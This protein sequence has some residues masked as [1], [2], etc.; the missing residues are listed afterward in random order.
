MNELLDHISY[1]KSNEEA[2]DMKNMIIGM[3][4]PPMPAVPDGNLLGT[5]LD[6]PDTLPPPPS[7]PDDLSFA[8]ELPDAL[9]PP[10]NLLPGC[11]TGSFKNLPIPP[12]LD[13]NLTLYTS[14]NPTEIQLPPPIIE[15]P[16]TV[17]EIL[18]F[19]NSSFFDKLKHHLSHAS[20]PVTTLA[21]DAK[22]A[23]GSIIF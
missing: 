1:E 17:L 22:A 5:V 13:E 4:L 3:D 21:S 12:P 15:D 9:P 6:L 16:S 19:S 2:F 23:R 14:A 11:S 20:D 10:S 7:L 8:L 18:S